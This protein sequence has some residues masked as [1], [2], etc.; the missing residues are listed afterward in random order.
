[1][2]MRQKIEKGNRKMKKQKEKRRKERERKRKKEKKSEIIK[3]LKLLKENRVF[4][5]SLIFVIKSN[6]HIKSFT[7][8]TCRLV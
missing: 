5:A 8:R 1:M 7:P 4:Q 6:A 2:K 3:K